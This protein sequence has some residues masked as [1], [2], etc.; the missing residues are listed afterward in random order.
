MT[1]GMRDSHFSGKSELQMLVMV[2]ASCA[3]SIVVRK[4]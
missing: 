2:D 1:L 3:L 4:V